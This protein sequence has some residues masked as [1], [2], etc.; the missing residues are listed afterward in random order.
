[1]PRF[2]IYGTPH[3]TALALTAAAVWFLSRRAKQGAP[4]ASKMPGIALAAIT[5]SHFVFGAWSCVDLDYDF[6]P[7]LHLCDFAAFAGVAAMLTRKPIF[8]ELTYFWGMAGTIQGLLTPALRIGFPGSGVFRVFAL[9][10]GVVAMALYL[11]IGLRFVPAPARRSAPFSGPKPTSPSR[12]WAAGSSTKT[13]GF[14]ARSPRTAACSTSSVRGPY[15]IISLELLA[16]AL[17]SLLYLPF[18][19]RNRSAGAA[20]AGNA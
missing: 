17:Y 15:Y 11:V 6:A 19:R 9:H 20:A 18:W 4:A 14:S 1:M 12:R 5:L 8:C 3:L 13:T 7:P 2:E 16:L 10:C